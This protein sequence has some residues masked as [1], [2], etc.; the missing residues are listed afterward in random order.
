MLRNENNRAGH[1]GNYPTE[2]LFEQLNFYCLTRH[3]IL[4]G[5]FQNYS[6]EVLLWVLL[7]GL[8][9][10]LEACNNQGMLLINPLQ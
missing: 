6:M 1:G 4:W 10:G 8:F 9:D 3:K 7:A 2:Q 5:N